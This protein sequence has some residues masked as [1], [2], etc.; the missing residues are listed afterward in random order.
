MYQ[1]Q[2]TARVTNENLL[3]SMLKTWFLQGFPPTRSSAIV[4]L[5]L[6]SHETCMLACSGRTHVVSA[7]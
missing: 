3:L 7:R 1:E 6:L 5:L 4:C 2:I